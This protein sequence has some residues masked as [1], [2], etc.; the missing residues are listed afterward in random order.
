MFIRGLPAVLG[1]SLGLASFALPASATTILSVT[2]PHGSTLALGAT[3]QALVA[4]WS[5]TN[6]YS[7]VSISFQSNFG[8]F[9]GTAYLMSQIGP[10]TTS[11]QQVAIAA[12]SATSASP[13]LTNLFSGL[14][15]GPGSYYLVLTSS[16]TGGWDTPYTAGPAVV[17]TGA[18]V[19]RGAQFIVNSGN[20]V[21]DLSYFP[22]S[23]FSALNA[24]YDLEFQ[25]TG[26]LVPEPSILLLLGMS[27]TLLQSLRASARRQ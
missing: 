4:S 14:T 20:G 13:A 6:T 10:G 26:S 12:Y 9:D 27:L 5:S 16:S 3:N 25:V 19:T 21:P 24:V 2:G 11:A 8:P 1:V 18:G 22:A 15:L 7:G 23:S 17:S